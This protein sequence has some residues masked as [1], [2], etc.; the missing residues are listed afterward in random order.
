MMSIQYVFGGI[1]WV[2]AEYL[3]LLGL[4]RWLFL[5]SVFLF[6]FTLTISERRKMLSFTL[7]RYTTFTRW[8][9][10]NWW[11]SIQRVLIWYAIA[12]I[13]CTIISGWQITQQDIR[14]IVLYLVH[15]LSACAV[16]GFVNF[17][18]Y[19]S[20]I[21]LYLIVWEGISYILSVHENCAW[22]VSG[23]YVRSAAYIK[24]G[25]SNLVVCGLKLIV[26]VVCYAAVVRLWKRGFVDG[27]EKQYD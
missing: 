24:H 13:L 19:R 6:V 14:V 23:M 12:I 3:D 20:K 22:L 2:D 15:I 1:E 9:H 7:Y 10:H 18:S 8:W 16:V 25:F 11:N 17:V 26:I 21:V 4:G 27:R 5:Y